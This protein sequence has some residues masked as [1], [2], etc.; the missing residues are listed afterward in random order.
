MTSL[1]QSSG[2][3]WL[4]FEVT[5]CSAYKPWTVHHLLHI[6]TSLLGYKSLGSLTDLWPVIFLAN[7]PLG[8]ITD[9][10]QYH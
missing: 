2:V 1:L 5:L 4:A 7:K 10:W 8:S 3:F 9:Y 6:I